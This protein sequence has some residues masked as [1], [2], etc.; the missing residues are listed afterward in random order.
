MICIVSWYHV[1]RIHRFLMYFYVNFLGEELADKQDVILAGLR[2]I[3]TD[4]NNKVAISVTLCHPSWLSLYLYFRNVFLTW[5]LCYQVKKALAQTI[6]AMAHHGYLELEGGQQMIEFIVAQCA[7]TTPE[8]SV[9]GSICFPDLV[10]CCL[11]LVEN[12]NECMPSWC[13]TEQTAFG[14]WLCQQ[15]GSQINVW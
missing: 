9:G 11:S 14:T 10:L 6:I 12:S 8:P 5:S 4:P 2:K 3:L 7:F 15:R 1:F 13:I